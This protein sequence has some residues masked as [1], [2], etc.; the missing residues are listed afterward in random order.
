MP[1]ETKE[2]FCGA[3]VAG[4]AALVGAGTASATAQDRKKNKK[5][6]KIIFWISV[7]VTILSILIAIYILFIRKCKEC[8]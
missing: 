8:E 6:Q 7:G 2:S 3:C 5:K 1:E 4:V